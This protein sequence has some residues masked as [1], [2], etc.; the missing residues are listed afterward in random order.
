MQAL[1]TSESPLTLKLRDI[2]AQSTM[3][4]KRFRMLAESAQVVVAV[5][6][7]AEIAGDKQACFSITDIVKFC[8]GLLDELTITTTLV[9][10][11]LLTS[12]RIQLRGLIREGFR[13]ES[14]C[15]G[16]LYRMTFARD[17]DLV[18][19]IKGIDAT[20]VGLMFASERSV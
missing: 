19:Y 11:D 8:E 20:E 7:L 2:L 6:L 1:V 5:C 16:S 4:K 18:A 10:T 3:F 15:Y 14:D 17:D 12:D 13:I 9:E